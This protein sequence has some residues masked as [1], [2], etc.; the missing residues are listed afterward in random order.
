MDDA[1]GVQIGVGRLAVLV[2]PR[3]GLVAVE[4]PADGYK[5]VPA[6]VPESGAVADLHLPLGA[7]VPIDGDVSQAAV[8]HHLARGE[9]LGSFDAGPPLPRYYGGRS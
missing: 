1:G 7:A 9:Q 3:A 8:R 6:L 5:P 4:H 2:A